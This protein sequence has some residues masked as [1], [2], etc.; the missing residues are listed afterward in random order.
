MSSV[1]GDL[2]P[3]ALVIAVGPI[4][5]I[6]VI[7]L[8]FSRHAAANSLAFLGG[9][10]AGLAAVSAIAVII[11]RP[12]LEAADG[13]AS[14][15]GAI[16]QLLIGIG[17][18]GL[19]VR[20][21]RNRSAQDESAKLPDWLTSIEN[22]SPTR[23]LSLGLLL[24]G[25]NIKVVLLTLAAMMAVT[26]ANLRGTEALIAVLIYVVVA[27]ST[28]IVPVAGNLLLGERATSPLTTLRTWLERHYA[29]TTVVVLLIVGVVLSAK[30][31][32]TLI[33]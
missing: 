27:S 33:G 30:G 16:L 5:I 26:E 12:A 32:T 1:L 18:I 4:Q 15:L 23:A 3:P 17:L 7:L 6:A 9:W 25:P 14:T 22:V 11:E 29:S 13:N 24:S 2:L 10:I 28:V 19:A 8:L 21:W 20:Q 31:I